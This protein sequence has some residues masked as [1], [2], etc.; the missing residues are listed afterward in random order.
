MQ[1]LK[2]LHMGFLTL[3]VAGFSLPALAQISAIDDTQTLP[4][5]TDL[6]LDPAQVEEASRLATAPQGECVVQHDFL[7][8]NS[9][10][11]GGRVFDREISNITLRALLRLD[12][13]HGDI[14]K[15]EIICHLLKPGEP[16]L[17]YTETF[18]TLIYRSSARGF[19]KCTGDD[20]NA[21]SIEMPIYIETGIRASEFDRYQCVMKFDNATANWA[22]VPVDSID[23]PAWARPK[24]GTE[25][26][27][28]LSGPLNR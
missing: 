10:S 26:V 25:F 5:M 28:M 19:A 2:K 22:G 17:D 12:N 11:T 23:S 15:V 24:S 27:K 18:G 20:L 16:L 1:K 13:L 14:N 6:G 8:T 21:T 9:A 4:S 3:L 7:L